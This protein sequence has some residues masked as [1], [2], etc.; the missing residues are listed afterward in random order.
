MFKIYGKPSCV[1]CIKAKNLL[2]REG[3]D[4][5]Y[6]DI[7]QDE[8]A[9]AYITNALKAKTVPQIL[10]DETYVGGYTELVEYLEG[11]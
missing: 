4:Y 1:F 10:D 7:T 2:D 6:I 3:F 8:S 9:K 11:N 5:E